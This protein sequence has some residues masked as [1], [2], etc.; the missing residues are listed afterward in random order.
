MPFETDDRAYPFQT[1]PN[2]VT[3]LAPGRLAHN[4]LISFAPNR[5]TI[6][7]LDS[8]ENEQQV[9][10][11][12]REKQEGNLSAGDLDARSA[13]HLVRKKTQSKKRI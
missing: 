10:D 13:G 11:S 2:W 4:F 9:Q 1:P 6:M 5:K 8:E 12:H 3:V 7:H